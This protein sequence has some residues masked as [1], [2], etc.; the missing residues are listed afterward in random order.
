[1]AP[2]DS[3]AP[4]PHDFGGLRHTLISFLRTLG[5]NTHTFLRAAHSPPPSHSYSPRTLYRAGHNKAGQWLGLPQASIPP[6]PGPVPSSFTPALLG[7]PTCPARTRRTVTCGQGRATWPV[8]VD[9]G[10]D[11]VAA[12]QTTLNDSSDGG[13][14]GGRGHLDASVGISCTTL[15]HPPN[16]PPSPCRTRAQALYHTSHTPFAGHCH[17][18]LRHLQAT[19]CAR[20]CR[21]LPATQTPTNSDDRRYLTP[22]L[23]AC[24]ANCCWAPLRCTVKTPA[25]TRGVARCLPGGGLLCTST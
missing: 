7:S 6:P 24:L 22:T 13:R 18:D 23:P 19:A 12:V 11:M 5:N 2:T 21:S 25:A 20:R 10:E 8:A 14:A 1:M 15:I 17:G 9:G 4:A 3:R 16:I